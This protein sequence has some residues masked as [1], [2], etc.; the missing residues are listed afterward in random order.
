MK[1][2]LHAC[3]VVAGCALASCQPTADAQARPGGAAEPSRPAKPDP[4]AP[5][6]RFERDMMMR[7]HMHASFDLA[8]AVERVLIRGKL[9]DA[10][11]LAAALAS[12]AEPPGLAPWA[13]QLALVRTRAQAVAGAPGIDEAC[14]GAARLAEAC[15]RCHIDTRAQ[16]E[17]QSPPAAPEDRDTVTARMAR[18]Q[19][20][21]NRIWE[22]MVGGADDAWTA[23][24]EV[25]A[26][27]PL[28]WPKIE[29][30]R[31]K[32]ASRLQQLAVQAKRVPAAG[33]ADRARIYGDILVT[34]A[35]CHAPPTR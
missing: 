23:G 34:C 11:P 13:A 27:T 16:A 35:A 1:C 4:D 12:A 18:H 32:L 15:A 10:R 17:F 29:P 26:T 25:L 20:A 21:V 3:L 31:A 30:E 14:R 2:Q 28:P 5:G 8:R 24:L 6:A 7:F 19:W 33:L 9:E 22:G